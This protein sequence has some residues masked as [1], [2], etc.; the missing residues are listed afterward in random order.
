MHAMFTKQ[1]YI[2]N[3]ILVYKAHTGTAPSIIIIP[4]V[5]KIGEITQFLNQQWNKQI[6]QF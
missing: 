6:M 2:K 1:K 5:L 4:Q 3:L